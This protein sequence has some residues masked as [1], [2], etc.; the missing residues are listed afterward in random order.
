MFGGEVIDIFGGLVSKASFPYASIYYRQ[1]IH[2]VL[3]IL[4]NE[5]CRG[6]LFIVQALFTIILTL[7]FMWA[8]IYNLSHIYLLY[9]IRTDKRIHARV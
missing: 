6:Q 3:L 7:Q 5:Y 9:L 2:S 4:E 1:K 8:Q